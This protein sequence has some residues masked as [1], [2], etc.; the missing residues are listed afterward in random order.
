[1]ATKRKTRKTAASK[2][3]GKKATKKK[4]ARKKAGANVIR[5]PQRR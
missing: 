2:Q 5:S 1:M 4:V 3:A